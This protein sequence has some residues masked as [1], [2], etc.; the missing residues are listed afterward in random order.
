MK[1]AEIRKVFSPFHLSP[2]FSFVR[3]LAKHAL[4][5][6]PSSR[7]TDFLSYKH[8]LFWYVC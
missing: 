7:V 1:R 2:V 5:Q 8:L 6:F 4:S 3:M